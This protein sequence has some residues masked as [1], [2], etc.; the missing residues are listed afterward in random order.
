MAPYSGTPDKKAEK[1]HKER[2]TRNE[3]SRIYEC[4]GKGLLEGVRD[5]DIILDEVIHARKSFTQP[6][7]RHIDRNTKQLN[8]R[9]PVLLR[10]LLAGVVTTRTVGKVS[11][12]EHGGLHAL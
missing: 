10:A 11:W 7:N 6:G 3:T 4:L 2:N 12:E 9:V 5:R 1:A 8:T